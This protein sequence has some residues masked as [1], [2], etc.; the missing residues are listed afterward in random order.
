M[1]LP[2][3][4]LDR[5]LGR[6]VAEGLR[7]LG[8]QI[9]R[10][11]DHFPDDAQQTDDEVWL[12]CGLERGWVPM[13]KDGRIRGRRTE[14]API[15]THAAVLFY[16]DNQQLRRSEMISRFHNARDAIHRAIAH[17]GPAIYAVSADGIRRT[18]P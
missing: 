9:H 8:W 7:E 5:G 13:C 2:E 16:L 6:G 17:G 4:F 1:S 11:T 15:E 14:R 12:A 18:W 10:I 3:F